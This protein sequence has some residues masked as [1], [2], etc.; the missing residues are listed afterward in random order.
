[1]ST[2]DPATG[3]SAI[4]HSSVAGQG[5]EGS[6]PGFFEKWAK[7]M[8]G[9]GFLLLWISSFHLTRNSASSAA[10]VAPKQLEESFPET[11]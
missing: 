2:A 9:H 5:A 11:G 10:H 8:E 7:T 1:M 6:F 4:R 3:G